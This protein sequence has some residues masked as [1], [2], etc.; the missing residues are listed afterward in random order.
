MSKKRLNTISNSL[1]AA[2][3]ALAL[4]SCNP[5]QPSTVDRIEKLQ[6]Q[7]NTDVKA[8]QQIENEE[9]PKLNK[10][11]LY[12]D[13]LLQYMD[14]AQVEQAFEKL[15]LTQAYLKQFAELKGVM[16]QNAEYANL[17]L[18]HLKADL[19]SQYINDS[20]ATIYLETETKVADTL[21][22]RILY[23]QDRFANCSKEMAAI[24][25]ASR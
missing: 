1:V 12:C 23:F 20:L 17:Q 19:E 10:A 15:N 7:V 4:G 11:F 13:S 18:D 8:L 9:Y 16:H 6:K 24:K 2:L 3:I 21:H 22:H 5:K 14:S 25:K